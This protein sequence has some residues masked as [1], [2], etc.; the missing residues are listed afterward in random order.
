MTL[1]PPRPRVK[2]SADVLSVADLIICR[3]FDEKYR[4]YPAKNLD[5]LTEGQAWPGV[6]PAPAL[7]PGGQGDR[8]RDQHLT[9]LLTA[10][11]AQGEA[12]SCQLLVGT[13]TYLTLKHPLICQSQNASNVRAVW[14][15]HLCPQTGLSWKVKDL[16]TF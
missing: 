6:R 5:L 3:Y 12:V 16:G 15:R 7:E 2:V 11:Q 4:Q 14:R 13:T 9:Q 10:L 8:D 1:V